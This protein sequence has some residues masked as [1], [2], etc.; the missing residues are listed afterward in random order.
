M[1]VLW[2]KMYK[3][4]A[5]VTDRGSTLFA[6]LQPPTVGGPLIC[7]PLAVGD[8]KVVKQNAI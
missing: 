7:H 4:N 6:L 2:P 5:L 3:A 1:A 8:N